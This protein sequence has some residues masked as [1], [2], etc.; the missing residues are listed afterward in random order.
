MKAAISVKTLTDA[1][2][3]Q[4]QLDDFRRKLTAAAEAATQGHAD[5]QRALHDVLDTFD[6]MFG[7]GQSQ[8]RK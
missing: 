6:A 7:V 8:I 4:A 1:D 2:S 3:K 5:P